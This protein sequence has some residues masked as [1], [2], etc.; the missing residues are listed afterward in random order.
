M[1]LPFLKG[2]QTP[3][4]APPMEEKLVQGSADDHINEHMLGELM[5]AYEAKDVKR[6]RQSMEGLILNMLNFDG[7]KEDE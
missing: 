7:D 6:F 4:I 2:R 1:K 5:D 3:R